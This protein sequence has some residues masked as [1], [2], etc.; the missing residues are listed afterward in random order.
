MKSTIFHQPQN[1]QSLLGM[2]DIFDQVLGKN[3]AHHSVPAPLNI[4]EKADCFE[5]EVAAPGLK[6][7][8]FHIEVENNTLKISAELE[9]NTEKQ[10]DK[11]TTREFHIRAFERHLRLS[12][13]IDNENISATYVDG[14][15]TVRLAKKSPEQ[16]KN[17]RSIVIE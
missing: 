4:K 7:E 1:Y 17:I 9:Q 15:L 5:V 3:F 11:Y 2:S 6:K 10:A 8:N 14:I 16:G 12:Q 13:N